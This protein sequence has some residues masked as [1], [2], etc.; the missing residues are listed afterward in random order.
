[1]P[2]Q[3][4]IAHALRV[5]GLWLLMM[6]VFFGPVSLGASSAL[7]GARPCGSACPCDG[8]GDQTGDQTGDQA[9]DR[10]H[11]HAADAQD[12]DEGE[13]CV[14]ADCDGEDR[15]GDEP[16]ED[17]CPEDC[18][19]CRCFVTSAV[20]FSTFALP[21]FSRPVAS[22]RLPAPVDAPAAGVCSGVFR[23]PRS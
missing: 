15:A 4:D 20:V 18:P 13:A 12:C 2:N 16:C 8:E 9:N 11:E 21:S 22:A 3:Q 6:A 17:D 23:P 19:K 10:G 14:D 1:M 5:A 7:A